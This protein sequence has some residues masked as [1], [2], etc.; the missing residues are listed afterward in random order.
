MHTVFRY[1]GGKSKKSVRNKILKYFP[2]TYSEFRD[3]M[4]GGGGIFFC[5]PLTV[6]RWINDLDVDLISVYFALKY[7]SVNF[8]NKCREILP[9]QSGE[10]DSRLKEIFNFYKNCG[11][12]DKALRYYFIHRTVWN[13]RVN[14]GIPSR[15]YFSNPRGWSI[16]NSNK[17]EKAAEILYNTTV[18]CGDYVN[19]FTA[20]GDDILIYADP[21]YFKNTKLARTSQLYRHNFTEED[22]IKLAETVKKCDHKVILSYDDDPF[23]RDLYKGFNINTDEWTYCG[24]SS[25]TK[26]KGLELIITNYG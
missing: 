14:Y 10:D 13:G 9:F 26:R 5:V 16:V 8:I 12:C 1:P 21:P 4:V 17:L 2:V 25:K 15:L 6:K 7:D 19:L 23:I 18:T 22:H 20:S 11:T 24:T 3:C